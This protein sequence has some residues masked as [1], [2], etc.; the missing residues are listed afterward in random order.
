MEITRE[1]VQNFRKDLDEAMKSVG[2]K[3]GLSV[4]CGNI[5]YSNAKIDV[6]VMAI[7]IP[8]AD[9][10]PAKEEWKRFVQFTSLHEDDFGKAITIGG[11]NYTIAGCNPSARTN[12]IKLQRYDGKMFVVPM[13]DVVIKLQSLGKAEEGVNK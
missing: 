1:M 10:D 8:T 4:N 9:F 7:P 2:E 12:N 13:K 3:Y 5:N 6:K 11:V